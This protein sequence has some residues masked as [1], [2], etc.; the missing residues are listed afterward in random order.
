MISSHLQKD[1]ALVISKYRSDE[2][3]RQRVQ[4]EEVDELAYIDIQEYK[5]F[6]AMPVRYDM[7]DETEVWNYLTL[8]YERRL[9]GLAD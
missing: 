2:K 8:E 6:F 5:R 3:L 7:D 4:T 9:S 1:I